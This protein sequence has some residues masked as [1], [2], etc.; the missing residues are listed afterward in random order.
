MFINTIFRRLLFTII[1]L[2]VSLSILF[3]IFYPLYTSTDITIN[4]QSNSF[5]ICSKYPNLWNNLKILYIVFFIIS[6]FIYSNM[7]YPIFFNKN[8]LKISEHQ[9]NQMQDLHLNILN[10]SSDT[11][12]IIPKEGLYQ[13]ILITGTIRHWKNELCY[14]SIY[15]AINRV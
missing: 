3:A 10:S 12:I 5:N 13:N 2:I 8:K 15:K 6:N 1:F 4:L 9:K 11:P 14:V 7:I